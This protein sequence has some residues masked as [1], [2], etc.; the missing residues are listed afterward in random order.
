MSE[1]LTRVD[2]CRKNDSRFLSM[3]MIRELNDIT[4]E[5]WYNLWIFG[6]GTSYSQDM[7]AITGQ[8]ST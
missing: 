2:P 8:A 1:L 7:Y 5:K 6:A 4:F 3:E